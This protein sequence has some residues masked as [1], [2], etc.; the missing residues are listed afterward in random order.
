MKSKEIEKSKR[1]SNFLQVVPANYLIICEGKL[2]TVIKNANIL[3][4]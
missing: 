1:K 4:N 3:K 2:Y